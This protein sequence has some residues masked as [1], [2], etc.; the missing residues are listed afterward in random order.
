MPPLSHRQN[1]TEPKGSGQWKCAVGLSVLLARARSE[2]MS[3]VWPRSDDQRGKRVADE[4][5]VRAAE[6][7]W[8][9]FGEES[10]HEGANPASEFVQRP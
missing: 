3:L 2:G 5:W 1:I 6:V 8:A 4:A 10:L 7:F 9:D